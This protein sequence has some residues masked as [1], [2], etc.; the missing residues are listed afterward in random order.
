[1]SKCSKTFCEHFSRKSVSNC[2]NN[3]VYSMNDC[4]G[5]VSTSEEK[6]DPKNETAL[7]VQVGGGHYKDMKIQPVEFCFANNLNNGQSA[8]IKYVCRYKTKN[9]LEDLKKA[10]HYIDLLIQ[11]EGY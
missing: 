3:K 1:M 6:E 2:T 9:K 11:L 7:D 8:I 4:P 5:F 10:K